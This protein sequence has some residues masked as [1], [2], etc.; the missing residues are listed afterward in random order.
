MAIAGIIGGLMSVPALIISMNALRLGEAQ[1]ADALTISEK[2]RAEAQQ[3]KADAD[4]ASERAFAQRISVG[5][6]LEELTLIHTLESGGTINVTNGNTLSTW[7][8]IFYVAYDSN[9]I[10][11]PVSGMLFSAP[12]CGLATYRIGTL[13]RE[14]LAVTGADVISVVGETVVINPISHRTWT[15]GT[16]ARPIPEDELDEL[17]EVAPLTHFESP[18]A[19]RPLAGCV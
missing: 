18:S 13:E 16:E 9:K 3:A 1:R 12:A 5:P 2:Q 15:V 7:V 11:A 14:R 19:R 6:E 17:D 10:G 8:A 4:L